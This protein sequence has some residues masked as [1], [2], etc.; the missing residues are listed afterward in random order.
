[1]AHSNYNYPHHP[2]FAYNA[3]NASSF[4]RNFGAD[5]QSFDPYFTP[6]WN[7]HQNQVSSNVYSVNPNITEPSP[8]SSSVTIEKLTQSQEQWLSH[9]KQR[10]SDESFVNQFIH[11]KLTQIGEESTLSR[12]NSVNNPDNLQSFYFPS[13]FSYCQP[14]ADGK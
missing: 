9:V 10:K 5:F 13:F 8:S 6:V 1:M 2:S 3:S 14:A 12:S 4:F 7:Q 11:S